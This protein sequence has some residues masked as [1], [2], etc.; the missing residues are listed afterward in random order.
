[1]NSVSQKP[2]TLAIHWPRFGPY[3]LARIRATY[4][5]LQPFGI[6]VV[7]IETAGRDEI[8]GWRQE[9]GATE[10]ERIV[11][12]PDR[13]GEHVSAGEMWRAISDQL[14]AHRRQRHCHQRL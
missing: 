14:G 9:T 7:G 4:N 3:H 1:M 5:Y 10:F 8:Y 13:V 6:R 12:F 11:L 2:I